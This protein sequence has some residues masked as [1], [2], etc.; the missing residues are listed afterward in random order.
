M[1]L[2]SLVAKANTGEGIDRLAG[3]STP[4]GFVGAALIAD[5]NG[6][7]VSQSNPLSVRLYGIVET[8]EILTTTSSG[9]TTSGAL[10]VSITNVGAANGTV[11]G[12]TIAPG[13]SINISASP[14]NTIASFAYD[15]TGTTFLIVT[16][17]ENAQ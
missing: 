12:A 2:D 9:N 5:S 10:S 11:D 3:R 8:P 16:M 4:D 7:E 17:S 1:A 15:A 14:G 6:A 13:L